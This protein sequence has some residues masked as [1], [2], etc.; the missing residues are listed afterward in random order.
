MRAARRGDL[1]LPRFDEHLETEEGDH[2]VVPCIVH[3]AAWLD[4]ERGNK[5]R[6]GQRRALLSR[7][8]GRILHVAS[9]S[10]LEELALEHGRIEDQNVMRNLLLE[11]PKCGGWGWEIGEKKIQYEMR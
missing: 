8:A 5:V 4:T 6:Q 3:H 7:V 1:R 10:G 2:R 9:L 11:R